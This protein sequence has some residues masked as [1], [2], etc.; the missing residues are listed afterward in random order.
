MRIATNLE[1][2]LVCKPLGLGKAAH[3]V[4]PFGRAAYDAT[5]SRE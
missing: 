1:A 4:D 2:L 3:K 5:V